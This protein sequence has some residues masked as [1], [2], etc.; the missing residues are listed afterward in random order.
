VVSARR[1]YR[2]WAL[3]FA[4][5]ATAWLLINV[6]ET[7]NVSGSDFVGSLVKAL[8]LA[9][10]IVL[11]VEWFGKRAKRTRVSTVWPIIALIAVIVLAFV[12]ARLV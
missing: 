7:G 2:D 9:T 11:G 12:A 8:V 4:G 6:V 3:A 5:A 10:C 1:L